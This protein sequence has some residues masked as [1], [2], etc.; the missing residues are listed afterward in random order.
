MRIY[1][2]ALS[3]VFVTLLAGCGAQAA[4]MGGSDG[5]GRALQNIAS[6]VAL[7]HDM[8]T[9]FAKEKPE[10]VSDEMHPSL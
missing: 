3:W 1:R 2:F 7:G 5:A 9:A 10:A 6:T 4:E 8:A